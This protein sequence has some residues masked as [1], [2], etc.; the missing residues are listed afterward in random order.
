MATLLQITPFVLCSNK[1]ASIDFFEGVL[2]FACTYSDDNYAFL[3]RDN[4]A[5]RL[6]EV[7]PE[8]ELH[9]RRSQ[10]H[11]YIDVDDVDGLYAELKPE[12]DKLPK[13]RVRPPFD[14]EYGQR[15]LHVRDLVRAEDRDRVTHAP[16][17]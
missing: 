3:R 12:L 1:Q 16:T 14:T 15:E 8:R 9:D 4:A 2:G 17:A 7:L 10:N 11:V 5:V 13:G 6:L